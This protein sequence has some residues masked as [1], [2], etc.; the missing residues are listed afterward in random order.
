MLNQGDDELLSWTKIGIQSIY[1]GAGQE[2]MSNIDWFDVAAYYQENGL[3]DIASP[4]LSSKDDGVWYNLNGQ[5][6]ERPVKGGLFF[7][8]GKK[9]MVK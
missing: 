1:R 3:T 6:V 7:R 8:N 9:V 2:R 4:E 5:R